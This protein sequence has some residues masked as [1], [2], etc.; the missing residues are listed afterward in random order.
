M[1]EKVFK[2]T[3]ASNVENDE[4]PT[5]AIIRMLYMGL[6]FSKLPPEVK[7]AV[8]EEM[9]RLHGKKYDVGPKLPSLSIEGIINKLVSHEIDPADLPDDIRGIVNDEIQKRTKMSLEEWWNT[10][11][12]SNSRKSSPVHR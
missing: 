11:H 8:T 7:A 9:E 6:Q 2:N 12:A 4:L 3:F 1:A 10:Y 5:G